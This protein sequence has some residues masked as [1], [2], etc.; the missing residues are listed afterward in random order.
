[1]RKQPPVTGAA[2]QPGTDGQS[3]A[4]GGWNRMQIEVKDLAGKLTALR[5]AGARIRMDMTQGVGGKQAVVDDPSGNPVELL[6][7]A[8]GN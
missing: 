5:T 1:M 2:S 7:A 8:T 4:P 3:P 6:E